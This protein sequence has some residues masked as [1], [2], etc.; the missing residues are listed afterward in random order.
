MEREEKIHLNFKMPKSKYDILIKICEE[1]N[2]IPY[3]D[4]I[5][6]AF[7]EYIKRRENPEYQREEMRQLLK[8]DR[9]FVRDL[10]QEDIRAEV[11]EE[12]R[13]VSSRK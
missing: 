3:T 2:N 5:N 1:R 8:S 11:Q 6:E 10:F 13:R 7:N 4:I 9:A 12:F